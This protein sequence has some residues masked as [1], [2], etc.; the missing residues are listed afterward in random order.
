M[1]FLNLVCNKIEYKKIG[2]IDYTML[3]IVSGCMFAGKTTELTRVYNELDKTKYR[4]IVVDY[5]TETMPYNILVTHDG[6]SIPCR[7]LQ[8]LYCMD[9]IIWDIIL[10]NEAQFFKGLKSFVLEALNKKKTIYL[11]GLDG[12]FKQEKFGEIIDLIPMADTY[13]KLYATCGCGSK[14]SFSKRISN[15]VSQYCPHDK[16]I[17]VCRACLS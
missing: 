12:D 2:N 7:K 14:A 10:I 11:F 15:E 5:N 9:S 13:I 6:N 16:Y 17:P 1:T 4:V 3:H 8:N